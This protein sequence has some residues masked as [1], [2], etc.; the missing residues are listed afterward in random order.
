M[1]GEIGEVVTGFALGGGSCA[2]S[3]PTCDVR[4]VNDDATLPSL[5][6]RDERA[7]CSVVTTIGVMRPTLMVVIPIGVGERQGG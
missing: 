6:N 7:T 4:Q 3:D 2:I 5:R 1:P